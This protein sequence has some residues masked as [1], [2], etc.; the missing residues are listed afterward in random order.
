MSA[1]ELKILLVD[2]TGPNP[3]GKPAPEALREAMQGSAAS[4]ARSSTATAGKKADTPDSS[5]RDFLSTM[6][7]LAGAFGVGGLFKAT[8]D[9]IQSFKHLKST[10]DSVA[11][12][13]AKA[14]QSRVSDLGW[15]AGQQ[16]GDGKPTT[17]V[18][19]TEQDASGRFKVT[20]PNLPNNG[21]SVPPVTPNGG[22]SIPPASSPAAVAR[23]A[24]AAAGMS[25]TA[26]LGATAAIVGLG[27]A[28]KRV[29]DGLSKMAGDLSVYS[30]AL[31]ASEA[32]AQMRE[33]RAEMDRARKL[34]PDLA[35]F[36]DRWS[37]GMDVLY[38]L[39]T[40]FY[41]IGLKSINKMTDD[42]SDMK[43]LAQAEWNKIKGNAEA[44][45][46]ALQGDIAGANAILAETS[47]KTQE[48]LQK[49]AKKNEDPT[50]LN[51]AMLNEFFAPIGGLDG[52]N[53]FQ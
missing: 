9:V 35:K 29:G 2:E 32:R 16:T 27:F 18:F 7:D 49:M 28:A 19:Q 26:A 53:F 33:M 17:R 45:A 4:A 47:K 38:R 40:D 48:I 41:S 50:A 52:D 22:R 12:T 6:K 44:W 30:G 15:P 39:Q 20:Q 24:N 46:K 37:K 3:V 13:S 21:L 36:Q 43:I 42:V 11:E 14:A 5:P 25:A 10:T 8:I 34:G 31:A 1:A 51:D 23:V